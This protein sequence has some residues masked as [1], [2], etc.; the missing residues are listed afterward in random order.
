VREKSERALKDAEHEKQINDAALSSLRSQMNPHFIFNALN[1]IQSYVYANDKKSASNYLGKFSELIRKILDSSSKE[2]ITLQE[3][4][5]LLQLY[6]D[7]EKARFGDTLCATIEVDSSI[8]TEDALIPP[9]L[10]QPYVENA[11]K[12]GL[13]HKQGDKELN[14]RIQKTATDEYVQIT[15]DDNGVGRHKST[16]LNRKRVNHNSFATNANEKR[17]NLIRNLWGNR[18]RVQIIDKQNSDGL[19]AGTKVI[20]TIPVKILSIV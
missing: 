2:R 7:I 1:T 10:I 17:F 19:S 14:I 3:E 12:H 5:D 8:D 18:A 20:I 16:E 9:M 13:L 15:V 6:I 11:I 4:I